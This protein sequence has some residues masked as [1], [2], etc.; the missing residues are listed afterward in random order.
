MALEFKKAKRNQVRVKISIGGPSGSGKTMSSLL[1]AYGLVKAE[2]PQMSDED[3]WGRICVIDTENGSGSLYV[4]TQVG[5]SR[6]G[7]YNAIDMAPPYTPQSFVDAIHMAEEHDMEVIIIDSLSHAW[8]GEGGALDQQSAIAARTGNSYT[9]WRSVTPQHNKLVD[10]MLQSKCHVIADIRAKMDYQQSTNSSGKKEVKAI[11]MGLVM[12][13][14]IE[15]EFTVSFM[16]DYEHVANAT[17]DRTG[18]FDGKYF[19]IT[20]ETGK[21]LYKWLSEG[22]P[23]IE[24]PSEPTISDIH[25]AETAPATTETA[26]DDLANALSMT[27]KL[28]KEKIGKLSKEERAPYVAK[29]KEICGVTN[30]MKV[31]D[32]NIVRELYKAFKE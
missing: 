25:K 7:E 30:Y 5:P 6:I 19:T 13:D 20:P 17:K 22:A 14:G 4:G 31:T 12:R 23:V 16:L 3:C 8:S 32:I 29:I 2:H 10:T 11:G 26:N 18:L 15:Y 27:D 28:I 1:M 24:T 9:S 21:Q